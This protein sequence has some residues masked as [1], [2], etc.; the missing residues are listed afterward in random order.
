MRSFFLLY[1]TI[2]FM[3]EG[4]AFG[5]SGVNLK[6]DPLGCFTMGYFVDTGC[7]FPKSLSVIFT[8]RKVSSEFMYMQ[9]YFVATTATY[10]GD[11]TQ[12]GKLEVD[13]LVKIRPYASF[14]ML[15]VFL[16]CMMLS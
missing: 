10:L 8:A 14:L 16:G 5:K 12:D 3:S 7:F 9:D 1:P 2:V 13:S 15:L 6:D 11:H 4:F